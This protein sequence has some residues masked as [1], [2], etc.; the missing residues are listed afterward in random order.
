MFVA[1]AATASVEGF[2]VLALFLMLP[3]EGSHLKT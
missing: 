1:Y 3:A 2:H